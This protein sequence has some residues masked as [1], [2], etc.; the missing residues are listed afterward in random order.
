MPQAQ[1]ECLSLTPAAPI[2]ELLTPARLISPVRACRVQY[3]GC[4]IQP[5]LWWVSVPYPWRMVD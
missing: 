4:R 5:V 1:E 2:S 3:E